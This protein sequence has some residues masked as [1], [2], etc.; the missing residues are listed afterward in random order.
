[1]VEG[2]LENLVMISMSFERPTAPDVN[3]LNLYQVWVAKLGHET[4]FNPL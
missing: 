2:K 3:F 4:H 1:M